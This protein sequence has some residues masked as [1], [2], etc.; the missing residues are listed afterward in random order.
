M[1]ALFH[2]PQHDV[3]IYIL[4]RIAQALNVSIRD[5]IE[6]SRDK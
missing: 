5:L 2:N 4:D 3:S 6:E 1:L